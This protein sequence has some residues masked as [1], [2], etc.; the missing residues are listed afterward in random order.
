VRGPRRIVDE[1]AAATALELQLLRAGRGQT[2][3][4]RE[5]ARVWA[6][7]S[8][9][10]VAPAA[11]VAASA[12]ATKAVTAASLV[13]GVV[14]AVAL[15]GGAI[16]G[17]RAARRP[18]PPTPSAVS[19][20]AVVT[21][22]VEPS[23]P[24]E[25]PTPALERAP[26]VRR[27]PAASEDTAARRLPASRLAAEAQLVLDARRDLREGNAASA[28][29]R[30]E[31]ARPDLAGGAL[32]QEREALTIEALHH[33]GQTGAAARRAREFLRAYPRSPHAASVSHFAGP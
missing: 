23:P 12:A 11:P 18:P 16:V 32:A 15:S 31:A 14:L 24:A 4:S 9:T 33:S 26:H 17:V 27:A 10:L 20:P 21:A 8:A 13:K 7:L 28:L 30:L 6:D 22:A 5:R 29:R 1:G 2:L 25:S 19:A 3:S